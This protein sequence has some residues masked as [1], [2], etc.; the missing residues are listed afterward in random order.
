MS[1]LEAGGGLPCGI[2]GSAH[3]EAE[4]V[5]VD[6]GSTLVMYT[7]GLVEGEGLEA[8]IR[9]LEGLLATTDDAPPALCEHVLE[10]MAVESS[11]PD[12]IAILALRT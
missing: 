10:E 3:Y 9:R 11:R 4:K 1:R 7:D 5:V 8:G 2:D 12:D 6:Q